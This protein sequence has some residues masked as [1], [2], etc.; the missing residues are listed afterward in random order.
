VDLQE[1][2]PR[3]LRDVSA[4]ALAVAALVVSIALIAIPFYGGPTSQLSF[5]IG[6]GWGLWER[7]S[8]F[9]AIFSLPIAIAVG[10]VVLRR[11]AV[12]VASGIFVGIGVVV[13]LRLASYLVGLAGPSEITWRTL[14]FFALQAVEAALL[15]LAASRAHREEPQRRS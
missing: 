14:A 10:I 12:P 4:T 8:N 5:V 9:L 3:S 6:G 7:I 2:A 11:D 13:A 1:R 15:F